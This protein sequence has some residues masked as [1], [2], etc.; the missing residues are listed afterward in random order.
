M[1]MELKF[2]IFVYTL[3]TGEF[4]D[5]LRF[6]FDGWLVGFYGIPTPVGY[7]MQNPVYTDKLYDSQTNSL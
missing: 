6:L 3:M 1:A 2:F 4:L 5:K 7:F